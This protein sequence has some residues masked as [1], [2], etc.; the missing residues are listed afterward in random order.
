MLNSL[1]CLNLPG[2]VLEIL[3]DCRLFVQVYM[4]K[5]DSTHGRY[6]GSVTAKDGKL[7]ID[8][9]AISVFNEYVN[10]FTCFLPRDAVYTCKH[11]VFL[12]ISVGRSVCLSV[13]SPICHVREF[14][15]FNFSQH[16]PFAP[17]T[18]FY[19]TPECHSPPSIT[20]Q[21]RHAAAM[22]PVATITV[23]TCCIAY[24]SLINY[25]MRKW[26]NRK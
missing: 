22:R 13:C 5:Y 4:F 7:V 21:E 12:S 19:H 11:A 9:K 24:D 18:V 2:V 1:T 14:R 3:T 25:I 17:C 23:A 8:G 10:S 26:L 6:P 20:Q 15:L 16:N